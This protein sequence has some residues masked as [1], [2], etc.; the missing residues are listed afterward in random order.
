MLDGLLVLL[1]M[2]MQEDI[3]RND[4]ITVTGV[5]R[6][7]TEADVYVDHGMIKATDAQTQ[8]LR[9]RA[10]LTARA[11]WDDDD[12]SILFVP[13]GQRTAAAAPKAPVRVTAS[14]IAANPQ[15]FFGKR[16]MVKGDVDDVENVHMFTLDEDKISSNTDLLVIN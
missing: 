12:G 3:D 1:P 7:F 2:E 6:Q 11:I 14:E 13:A 8:K 5:V 16:V 10:V 9:K 4:V 15:Q